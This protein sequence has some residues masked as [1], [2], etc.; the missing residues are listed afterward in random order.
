M[1]K[2]SKFLAG[3]IA[4][5]LIQAT[6]STTSYSNEF[7]TNKP[8]HD[9]GCRNQYERLLNGNKLVHPNIRIVWGVGQS[10]SQWA[11]KWHC[12]LLTSDV[13]GHAQLERE[14]IGMCKSATGI[15]PRTCRILFRL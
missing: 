4:A 1:S 5:T 15:N 9:V 13:K 14:V 6:A 12:Y 10:T 11:S 2:K 3:V 7:L 8:W